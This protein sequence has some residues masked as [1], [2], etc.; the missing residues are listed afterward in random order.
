MVGM[1]Y[2]GKN[3]VRNFHELG[4]LAVIC[5]SNE[6]SRSQLQRRVSERSL[7]TRVQF[8]AG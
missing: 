6:N 3:L 1:G 2:W 7:C 4:A 5:D 8:G